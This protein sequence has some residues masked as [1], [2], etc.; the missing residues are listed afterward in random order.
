VFVSVEKLRAPL[1]AHV[2]IYFRVFCVCLY[3]SMSIFA[4]A[5]ETWSMAR[6]F[7][8]LCS[9]CTSATVFLPRNE[10]ACFRYVTSREPFRSQKDTSDVDSR[11]RDYIHIYGYKYETRHGDRAK[12]RDVSL[13]R[14]M[15]ANDT[16]NRGTR[17]CSLPRL[18]SVTLLAVSPRVRARVSDVY[19]ILAGLNTRSGKLARLISLARD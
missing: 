14:T 5:R 10:C 3:V 4:R 11:A 12:L 18:Y 16:F 6:A 9:Y 1:C 2:S 19:S 7:K 13:S 17:L 15:N 8:H